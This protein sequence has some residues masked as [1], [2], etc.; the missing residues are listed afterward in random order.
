MT[1]RSSS[2]SRSQAPDRGEGRSSGIAARPG[3]NARRGQA[4]RLSPASS[5]CWL[6]TRRGGLAQ[7]LPNRGLPL[8]TLPVSCRCPYHFISDRGASS[9][10]HCRDMASRGAR[11][12]KL[13]TIAGHR[14]SHDAK[15]PFSAPV[16]PTTYGRA[17]RS[18]ST[19]S[20]P[21]ICGC[22]GTK[23]LRAS[24]CPT[25]ARANA[26][27]SFSRVVWRSATLKKASPK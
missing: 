19:F 13:P 7:Q 4:R 9:R 22:D 3:W 17:I 25:S 10:R 20:P 6:R 21:A 18:G 14:P 2:P 15:S 16:A 27:A 8:K 23:P 11:P 12:G 1:R 5:S 26:N 24:R